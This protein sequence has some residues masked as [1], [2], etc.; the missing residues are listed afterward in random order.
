MAVARGER[1]AGGNRFMTRITAAAGSRATAASA[2]SNAAAATARRHGVSRQLL[3]SWRK[4][5]R[6]GRLGGEAAETGF[7]PAIVTVEPAAARERGGSKDR[8]VEIVTANGRRIIF[9]ASVD[10][11]VLLRIVRGLEQP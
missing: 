2:I 10:A 9:E 5:W 6:E 7:A 1:N 11:A 3:L 8:R 4:A